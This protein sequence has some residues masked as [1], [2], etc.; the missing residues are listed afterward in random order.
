MKPVEVED[1]TYIDF[2]K[3]KLMKKILTSK[4]VIILK[5][6]NTKIVLLKDI[7]QIGLQNF[8]YL[9]KLK[10]L[11]HEHTLLVILMMKKLLEHFMKRNCKIQIKRNLG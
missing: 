3:K 8:F 1:N 5:Y 10:T 7:L 11:F 6:Q 9:M 4:L 2:G